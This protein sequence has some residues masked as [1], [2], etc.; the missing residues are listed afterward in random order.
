MPNVSG[1]GKKRAWPSGN[2]VANSGI[3]LAKRSP[4]NRPVPNGVP[5][6]ETH[7]TQLLR[8][9]LANGRLG[10][11][12]LFVGGDIESLESHAVELALT[13]NCQSPKATGETGIPLE[14]CRECTA[15][16]K[17]D[18]HNF[19]DLDIVRPE[20]KSRVV[21]VDQIRGL[22]QKVSLKPTEGRYKV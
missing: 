11:A 14:P 13:L 18:S 10:H 15:C 2:E 19:P 3:A 7:P 12:Y 16:R 17:V 8:R 21:T 5:E 9:S 20:S 6:T 1:R 4:Y 22:I